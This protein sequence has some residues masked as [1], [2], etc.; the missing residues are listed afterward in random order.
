MNVVVILDVVFVI[1]FLYVCVFLL[2]YDG[3]VVVIVWGCC[4]MVVFMVIVV[5][6]LLCFQVI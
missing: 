4:V 6:F 3:F 1:S 5:D 2:F